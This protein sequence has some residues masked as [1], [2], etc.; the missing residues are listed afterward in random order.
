MEE[1]SKFALKVIVGAIVAIVAL[2]L[3][4][5]S[6]R[7]ISPQE[8]GIVL[9]LGS[10]SRTLDNGLSFKF[11]LIEK[12]VKMDVSTISIPVDELGYSKDGQVV[13]FQ[14]TINYAL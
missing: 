3:L 5:G 10:I 1:D 12:V 7:I 14:A 11:P 13:Q 9:R 2:V 8:Q 6:F 4:F